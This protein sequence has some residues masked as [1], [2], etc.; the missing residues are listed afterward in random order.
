MMGER[1]E[2]AN[3]IL[4]WDQGVK[5]M[6]DGGGLFPF[7]VPTTAIVTSFNGCVFADISL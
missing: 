2:Q 6:T 1:S 5:Q 4:G 3:C 7:G